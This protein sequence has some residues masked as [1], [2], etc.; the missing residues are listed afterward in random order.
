MR[1][2][3]ERF[4]AMRGKRKFVYP[5]EAEDAAIRSGIAADPD[6]RELTDEEFKRLRPFGEVMAKCRAG[7]PSLESPK[8][9][10]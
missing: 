3:W 10:A 9:Q 5:T 1:G 8:E 2:L 6:A 4:N 7:R